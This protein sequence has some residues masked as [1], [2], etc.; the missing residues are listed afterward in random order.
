MKK[1]AFFSVLLAA[2]LIVTQAGAAVFSAEDTETVLYSEDFEGYASFEDANEALKDYWT[3]EWNDPFSIED[4]GRYF[5]LDFWSQEF[6]CKSVFLNKLDIPESYEVSFNI[7]SGGIDNNGGFVFLHTPGRAMTNAYFEDDGHK[8]EEFANGV[9]DSGIFIKPHKNK[10][11]IG[12]KTSET[13]DDTHTKGIGNIRYSVDLP[14]N[15]DFTQEFVNVTITDKDGCAEIYVENVLTAKVM[16]SSLQDGYYTSAS[17]SDASGVEIAVTA[18]AKISELRHIAL[19]VRGGD[20]SVDDIVIS[21]A[22][23]NIVYI[24]NFDN[25]AGFND[26]SSAMDTYWTNEWNPKFMILSQ[27]NGKVFN[28]DWGINSRQIFLNKIT[29]TENYAVSLLIKSGGYDNNGGFFFL[30]T[31][32]RALT[33]NYFEDDGHKTDD[34]SNGVGDCGIFI[35]PHKTQLVVGVKTTEENDG[36]HTK[37]I[38]NIR[39]TADLPD[40]SDF[41]LGYTDIKLE[42][43]NNTVYIYAGGTLLAS[44]AYTDL[45]GDTY[46]TAVIYNSHGD[47]VAETSTANISA[48]CHMAASVRGGDLKIDSITVKSISESDGQGGEQGGAENPPET[49]DSSAVRIAAVVLLMLVCGAVIIKRGLHDILQK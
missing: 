47:K 1:H 10:L 12:V 20:L 34:F 26:A 39:Y 23:E 5:K 43:K 36:S 49:G 42:D 27:E 19:S 46:K 4:K 18:S 15:I 7:K 44:V 40:G 11:V 29:L 41:T 48:Q 14:D 6:D 24:E 3:N 25:Y 28:M 13:V 21:D 37:G 8:T 38:G 22:E 35:K 9:G 30:H 17:V 33:N 2:V 31:P 16:Y 32:G 45:D